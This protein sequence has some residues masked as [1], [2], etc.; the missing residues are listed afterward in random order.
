MSE[1]QMSIR[2]FMAVISVVKLRA[3]ANTDKPFIKIVNRQS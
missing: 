1:M 3:K 2:V